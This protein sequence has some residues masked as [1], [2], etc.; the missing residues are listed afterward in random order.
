ME[1]KVLVSIQCL[2]YNHEPYLRQCLDGFV[3]QKTNFAFEAIVHDD[4]S[5]D[6]SADIIREYA[7]KYPSIIKPIYEKENQYSKTDGSLIRIMNA[8]VD[9]NAKYIAFCEGDDY[10]IDPY[11]LQKQ[12]DFLESHPDFG[13]CYTNFNIFYQE[14]NKMCYSLFTTKPRRFPSQYSSPASFIRS[15][16][17]VCPP[18]WLMR[19]NCMPRDVLP[20]VDGTFVLFVH[21]LCT[22]RVYMLHDVTA[23]YRIIKE[24]AS[25]SADYMHIYNRHRQLLEIKYKLI[26]IYNLDEDLKKLC[27]LDYYKYG[28]LGFVINNMQTDIKKANEVI[29]NKTFIEKLILFMA[30]YIPF[31]PYLLNCVYNL[32]R[33]VYRFL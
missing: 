2:V 30:N 29:V 17:Y 24:S 26:D 16:G 31:S 19:R 13:M 33:Y 1:Q 25:H 6:H 7:E 32:R 11:K 4:V 21:F 18:S 12:V 14:Y 5:T 28:L 15:N 20:S 9:I 27:E 8:A 23:V 10:W 22:S 3:M